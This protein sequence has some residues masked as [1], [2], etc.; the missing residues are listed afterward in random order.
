MAKMQYS[1]GSYFSMS[2]R[3][4]VEQSC[5]DWPMQMCVNCAEKFNK[6]EASGAHRT[7]AETK[8]ESMNGR[9]REERT[10]THSRCISMHTCTHTY[11]QKR[12]RKIWYFFAFK[13]FVCLFLFFFSPEFFV[14]FFSL[15]FG[16]VWLRGQH[17][18]T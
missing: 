18:N 6:E 12:Q 9:W 11:A 1:V 4:I 2:P 16:L 10:H 13:M 14:V 3:L 8:K 15:P 17:K 7:A 5:G